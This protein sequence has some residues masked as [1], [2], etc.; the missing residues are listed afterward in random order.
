MLAWFVL[1][2]V[3]SS[4]DIRCVR[5]VGVCLGCVTVKTCN[6]ARCHCVPVDVLAGIAPCVGVHVWH[7][8]R[9]VLRQDTYRCFCFYC[10]IC[11]EPFQI[12]L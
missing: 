10:T 5:I 3:C 1:S 2:G 6:V 7:G 9:V 12:G 8:V 4:C 11:G